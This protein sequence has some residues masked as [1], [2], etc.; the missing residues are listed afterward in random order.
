MP[1]LKI[2]VPLLRRAE[3]IAIDENL[4]ATQ[5]CHLDN[6]HQRHAS[7]VQARHQLC[8]RRLLKKVEWDRSSA[9]TNHR[10]TAAPGERRNACSEGGVHSHTIE[11]EPRPD[12][13]ADLTNLVSGGRTT[14]DDI[15]SP[16]LTG[17]LHSLFTRIDRDDSR[18]CELTQVLNRVESQPTDADYNRSAAGP[19]P[20]KCCFDG[21]VCSETGICKR[22]RLDRIEV[23]DGN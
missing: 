13:L 9:R 16:V 5:S 20:R 18:A 4:D 11:D 19:D 21:G 17:Q 23:A 8:T 7:A 22:C 14:R 15:V 12:S 1:M 3:W 10:E 2:L 6:L